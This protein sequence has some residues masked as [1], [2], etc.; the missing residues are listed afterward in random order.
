[1]PNPSTL[2]R[3]S[4]VI[5]T[6]DRPD[7]IGA[8]LDS[9]ASQDYPDFEVLV[10]D[11]SRG[12]ETMQLVEQA[13][14]RFPHVHAIRLRT[15]GL[16]D[17]VLGGGGPLQASQDFDLVYRAFR[18]GDRTLLEPDVV[19]Y[20]HGFRSHAEWPATVRSYGVGIGGFCLK[21]V[22]AGDPYAV[23]LLA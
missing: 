10:I 6:R 7:S 1:M 15:P 18:R 13:R 5:C 2:P 21:H 23:W 11:Q 8:A 14:E 20:H 9:V 19:V 4:V 12:D 3:V 22:R 17:E 16:S